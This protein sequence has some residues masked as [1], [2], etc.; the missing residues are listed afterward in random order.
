MEFFFKLLGF[1]IDNNLQNIDDNF[2]SVDAR[3]LSLTN[4]WKSRRL[5][6]ERRIFI[7]KSFLFSQYTYI[8]SVLQLIDHQI[9]TQTAINNF[10]MNIKEGE[11]Q[12]ISKSK[13]YQPTNK[14]GL[15]CISW[16]LF[17]KA[18]S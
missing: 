3:T 6:L 1:N 12:W 10:I 2:E 13:I 9:K 7:S 11:K 17:S 18:S 16:N 5:P 15:N 8:A 4:D 14:G